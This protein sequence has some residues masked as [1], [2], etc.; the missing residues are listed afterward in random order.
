MRASMCRGQAAYGAKGTRESFAFLHNQELALREH[1]GR[2]H[3]GRC[4]VDVLRVRPEA[5][6]GVGAVPHL[7]QHDQLRAVPRRLLS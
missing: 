4:A 6:V 1:G 3:L 2:D 5:V 7:R